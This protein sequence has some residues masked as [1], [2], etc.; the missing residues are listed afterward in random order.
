MMTVTGW[1]IVILGTGPYQNESPLITRSYLVHGRQVWL[2]PCLAR[3][4]W[5]HRSCNPLLGYVASPTRRTDAMKATFHPVLRT[6]HEPA[7]VIFPISHS[8]AGNFMR[9]TRYICVVL[10][11]HRLKELCGRRCEREDLLVG[12]CF[13]CLVCLSS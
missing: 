6:S 12:R 3:R 4:W 5:L 9:V 13:V 8:Q 1:K 10:T 7:R 11:S 2:H